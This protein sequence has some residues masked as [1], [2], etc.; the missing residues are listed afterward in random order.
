[1]KEEEEEE[2]KLVLLSRNGQHELV[3]L[4][5][6]LA[7]CLDQPRHAAGDPFPGYPVGALDVPV[8]VLSRPLALKKI[9]C[10][11]LDTLEP[12]DLGK[13]CWCH[14]IRKVALVGEKEDG[15]LKLVRDRGANTRFSA[16]TGLASI[17]SSSS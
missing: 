1:M 3:D 5:H 10:T 2:G 8:V 14:G 6:Q 16:S 12:H 4:F 7:R 11:Y 13:L 9:A 15:H 17:S